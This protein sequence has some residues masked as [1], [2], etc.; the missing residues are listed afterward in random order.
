MFTHLNRCYRFYYYFPWASFL[1]LLERQW[2]LSSRRF[3]IR[4]RILGRGGH[5]GL[6]NRWRCSCWGLSQLIL[7][8]LRSFS[9]EWPWLTYHWPLHFRTYPSSCCRSEWPFHCHI[10]N[11]WQSDSFFSNN[12]NR[13]FQNLTPGETKKLRQKLH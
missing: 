8:L 4:R 9:I 3:D 13:D 12:W 6:G 1:F 2:I 7:S 5:W 11:P 10:R